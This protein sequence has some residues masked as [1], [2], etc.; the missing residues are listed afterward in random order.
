MTEFL[1]PIGVIVMIQIFVMD[2]NVASDRAAL[3]ITV[4]RVRSIREQRFVAEE[5]EFSTKE[6][7]QQFAALP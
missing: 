1:I 2:G 5:A 7:M 3:P 6:E 4:L